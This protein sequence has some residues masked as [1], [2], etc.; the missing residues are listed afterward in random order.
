[1]TG[2]LTMAAGFGVAVTQ[3]CEVRLGGTLGGYAIHGD[4]GSIRATSEGCKVFGEEVEG[5]SLHLEY[6]TSDL[7]DYA[8]E[9][10]AFADYV[11]TG[12]PGP[13]SAESERRSLA[14]VQAGYESAQSGQ[15]VYLKTR[16]GE[17]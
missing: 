6:P 1:M 14:V 3:T 4:R 17:L 5:E 9:M 13:T 10:E 16:F 12:K 2:L 7:S 15:P 8:M 11:E